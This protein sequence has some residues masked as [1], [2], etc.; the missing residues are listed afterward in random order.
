MGY[1]FMPADVGQTKLAIRWLSDATDSRRIDGLGFNKVDAA[2]GHSL[3]RQS[4]HR[5][6]WSFGQ[7]VAAYKLAWRYRKQL[8]DNNI[9]LPNLPKVREYVAP[10]AIINVLSRLQAEQTT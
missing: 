2:F 3:A 4:Y 8:A 10:K 1:L 9:E 6:G 5:H 7:S